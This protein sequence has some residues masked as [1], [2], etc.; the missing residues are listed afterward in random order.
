VIGLPSPLSVNEISFTVQG[1]ILNCPS[2]R[3]HKYAHIAGD[4]RCGQYES[5]HVTPSKL[6]NTTRKLPY[7]EYKQQWSERYSRCAAA[8][9]ETWDLK[10]QILGSGRMWSSIISMH[11]LW[12]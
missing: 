3:K 8:A 12:I 5:K 6:G 10:G 2:C 9:A 11:H 7:H 1:R 4:A